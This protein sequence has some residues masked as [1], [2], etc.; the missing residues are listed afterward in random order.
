MEGEGVL[1]RFKL[2]TAKLE[3]IAKNAN[4]VSFWKEGCLL[5]IA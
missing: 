5:P 3:N 4:F 2:E 1:E